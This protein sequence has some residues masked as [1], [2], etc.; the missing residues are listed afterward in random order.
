MEI[1]LT[2]IRNFRYIQISNHS[3]Q[4]LLLDEN[5][6]AL[7]SPFECKDYLQDIFYCEYTGNSH[8]IWGLLWKKGML[9]TD[10]E[11]FKMALLGGRETLKGRIPHLKSF[12]NQLED[13]QGIPHTEVYETPNEKHIVVEFSKKWTES[14]PLLSAY[15]TA[16]RLAGTYEG[17]DII[18]YLQNLWKLFKTGKED[19]FPRYMRVDVERLNLSIGKLAALLQG[20]QVECC[21]EDFTD[22]EV[23][24]DTGIIG[25]SDFPMVPVNL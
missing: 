3:F 11:T 19:V 6:K 9:N 7:H 15:T 1:D 14:G 17:G 16:I 10:V 4:F 5:N 20:K 2:P 24:H 18:E 12:L 13:A 8:E 23:V 21:W 25:Y 22:I